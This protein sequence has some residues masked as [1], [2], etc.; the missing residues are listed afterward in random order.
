MRSGVEA[1]R[2]RVFVIGD[3]TATPGHGGA[4]VSRW[5]QRCQGL[6]GTGSGRSPVVHSLGSSALGARSQTPSSCGPRQAAPRTLACRA[7]ICALA[8]MAT[9]S[10]T[11]SAAVRAASLWRLCGWGSRTECRNLDSQARPRSLQTLAIHH[12]NVSA[13]TADQAGLLEV[14]RTFGH[15]FTS[16]TKHRSRSTPESSRGRCRPDGPSS[17][18]DSGGAADR[19][20]GAGCRR[21]SGQ[22]A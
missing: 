4:A 20:N 1:A 6:V 2:D 15:A 5:H 14:D 3:M 13:R 8:A 9:R 11:P 10:Q 21:R 17:A 19:A 22:F 12:G 7:V 18:A 16:D